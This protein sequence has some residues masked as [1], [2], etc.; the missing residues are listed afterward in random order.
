MDIKVS[1]IIPV[2]NT[3]E[4]LDQC[5]KSVSNQT[6]KDIEIICV[7]TDSKDKSLEIINN[8]QKIDN[9]IKIIKRNDGGLGGARNEGLKYAKGEYIA[10]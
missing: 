7:Y 2:F 6:L 1:V 8:W 9:R 5:L 10:F 4:Y 3:E